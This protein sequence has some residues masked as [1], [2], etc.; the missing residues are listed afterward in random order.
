MG[1]PVRIVDL[2]HDLIRLS[3]L[4][5]E[6]D[7]EIR[8]T[9]VRPGEKLFEELSTMS[10]GL[11]RTAHPKIFTGSYAT[12]P[13]SALR[14]AFES[15]AALC[16]DGNPDAIRVSLSRMVPEYAYGGSDSE[17]P[18]RSSRLQESEHAGPV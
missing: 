14:A 9:G 10:E 17:P 11:A 13:L 18:P 4:E 8:F 3:G 16:N 7:I 12:R 6:R 1:A 2:A 15:L 5:P